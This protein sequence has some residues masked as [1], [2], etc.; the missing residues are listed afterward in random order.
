MVNPDNTLIEV[1]VILRDL[2]ADFRVHPRQPYY[3][4]MEEALLHW[5]D[6]GAPRKAFERDCAEMLRPVR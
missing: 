6:N 5:L 4:V 3:E 1:P 2:L